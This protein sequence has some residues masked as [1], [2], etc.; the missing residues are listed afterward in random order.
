MSVITNSIAASVHHTVNKRWF[1]MQL[2]TI[3]RMLISQGIMLVE[4][5]GPSDFEIPEY[6]T[7][8]VA[9]EF[10]RERELL[11]APRIDIA[12]LNERVNF[13]SKEGTAVIYLRE[14]LSALADAGIYPVA[15]QNTHN[16]ES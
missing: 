15:A 7:E 1:K 16:V 2:Q 9:Q 11:N 3:E 12:Y 5:D 8:I 14:Y 6:I 13:A 4:A 10:W